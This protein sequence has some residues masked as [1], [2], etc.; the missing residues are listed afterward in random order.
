MKPGIT[1]SASGMASAPPDHCLVTIGASQAA[2]TVAEAMTTVNDRID[3]LIEALSG[4]SIATSSIQT[5]DLSIWPEHDREGSPTGFRVRNM[6]RIEI[7]EL[8]KVGTVVAAATARLGNSAEMQGIT[9]LLV[10]R[11][12]IEAKARSLAWSAARS[13]AE[14]LATEAEVRLGTVVSIVESATP[15]PGRPMMTAMA[16]AE[17]AP[18]EA[19]TTSVRVDITVRFALAG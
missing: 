9:F 13:K 18:I 7:D 11:A 2:T 5:V 4:E 16:M 12:A 10:D 19:G 14:Q 8:E 1:V 3:A 6:V 15:V 17:A